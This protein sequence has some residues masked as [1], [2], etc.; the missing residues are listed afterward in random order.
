MKFEG[1]R[2]YVISFEGAGA[3]HVFREESKYY[4]IYFSGL[5]S[6]IHRLFFLKK[7]I[8]E[9][10]TYYDSILNGWL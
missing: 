5:T 1:E 2:S 8:I 4:F 9:G 10:C 7:R 6:K 3:T